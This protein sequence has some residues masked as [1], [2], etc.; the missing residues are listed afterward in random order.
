MKETIERAVKEVMGMVSRFSLADQA[1][2]Y[3]EIAERL[4]DEAVVC[5]DIEYGFRKPKN[6]G[7]ENG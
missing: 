3:D 2:M 6:Q 5:M 4:G 1:R 7:H